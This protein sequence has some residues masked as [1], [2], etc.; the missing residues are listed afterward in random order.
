M[1]PELLYFMRMQSTSGSKFR[2]LTCVPNVVS[3]CHGGVQPAGELVLFSSLDHWHSR[4]E[5]ETG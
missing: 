3:R 1:K 2:F 5:E 4:F